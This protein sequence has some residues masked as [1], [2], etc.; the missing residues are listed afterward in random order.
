MI[1]AEWFNGNDDLTDTFEIRRKVFIEEQGVS[2][3][4]E[5]IKSEDDIS[6]HLVVYDANKPVATGR[7]IVQNS[8]YILGRIAVLKEE[9]GKHYG[10]FVVRLLIRKAYEMGGEEQHIHAQISATGFYEKLGFE[11]YGS[12]YMEAGIPHI[13]MVHK[14][15]ISCNCS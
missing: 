15:D 6:I 5:M 9:R 10:D 8:Q 2:E 1:V 13:N 7:I 14:G 11:C 4:L 12:N 3:E